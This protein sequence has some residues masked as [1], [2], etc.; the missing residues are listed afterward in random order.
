MESELTLLSKHKQLFGIIQLQ[1]KL[2]T[3]SSL[4]SKIVSRETD[5]LMLTASLLKL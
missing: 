3:K 5:V 1:H 4:R 2:Y